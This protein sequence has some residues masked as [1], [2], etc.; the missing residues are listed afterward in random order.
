M[1]DADRFRNG[2]PAYFRELLRCHGWVVLAVVE[3]FGKD[4]DHMDDLFQ[5]TWIRVYEKRKTFRGQGSFEAWLGRVARSVCIS[6]F[7]ARRRAAAGRRT[8][9]PVDLA[10][11]GTDPSSA[12]EKKDLRRKLQVALGQLSD[13]EHEVISLRILE[14]VSSDEVANR[15]G[16]SPATVRSNLRHGIQRLRKLMEGRENEL[17]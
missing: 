9:S 4:S 3:T 15:L 13:R 11:P 7:R 17:S 6:D 8:T 5:E 14:E 16:I 1:I 12:A 2:D 10:A